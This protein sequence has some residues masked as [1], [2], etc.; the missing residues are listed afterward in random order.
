[1]RAG[2]RLR[3]LYARLLH[4][5]RKDA[6]SRK[7]ISF[8]LI[9]VVN[10]CV[11]YGVFFLARAVFAHWPAALALFAGAAAACRC[12]GA[13]TVSFIAANLTSWAVAV[14]GSYIL[15]A[16]ITFAAES[17]RKLRWRAYFAFAASGIA[18]WLANTV[19]LIVAAQAL[20]LPV[21]LAKAIAIVASF[22]VNFTLSHYVVFRVRQQGALDA[23]EGI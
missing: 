6:V 23:R 2:S 11:D 16:S 12:S 15:N 21:A 22:A 18:G 20:L 10:A 8:A 7:A 1:M 14:T 9:G 13:D 5:W 19:A 3:K 17:G 4:G